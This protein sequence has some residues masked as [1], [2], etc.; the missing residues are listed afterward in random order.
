MIYADFAACGIGPDQAALMT[1]R[2]VFRIRRG[3]LKSPPAHWLAAMYMNFKPPK[4]VSAGASITTAS[5][6]DL[7]AL[8]LEAN[9]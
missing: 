6:S 8:M 4:G 5:E 2:D 1:M 9:G 3:W 7:D